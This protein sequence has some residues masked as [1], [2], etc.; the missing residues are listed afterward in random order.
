MGLQI[1]DGGAGLDDLTRGSLFVQRR[2][3]TDW[4]RTG[5]VVA[6]IDEVIETIEGNTNEGGSQEGYEVCRRIRNSKNKDFVRLEP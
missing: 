6:A 4:N 2:S 1:A 3:P 5:I